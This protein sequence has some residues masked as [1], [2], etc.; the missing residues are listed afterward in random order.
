MITSPSTCA[1]TSIGKTQR[2]IVD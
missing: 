1:G 2:R